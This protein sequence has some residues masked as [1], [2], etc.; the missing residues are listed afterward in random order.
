MSFVLFLCSS[1]CAVLSSPCRV[2]RREV[3]IADLERQRQALE[4]EKL[5][6]A[7]EKMKSEEEG[8]QSAKSG[9]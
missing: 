9:E 5:K 6:V 1:T 7:L 4:T 3:V 8:Q 2:K